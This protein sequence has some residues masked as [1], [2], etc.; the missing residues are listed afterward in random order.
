MAAMVKKNLCLLLTPMSL[1]IQSL[2]PLVKIHRVVINPPFDWPGRLRATFC[3]I[4]LLFASSGVNLAT[5]IGREK[6][7]K[8]KLCNL[9]F[10]PPKNFQNVF[11]N[12]NECIS[13]E[14]P[15]GINTETRRR[16]LD[17]RSTMPM[18][19][20]GHLSAADILQAP[21]LRI[22]GQ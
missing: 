1:A 20:A 11:E 21:T 14:Q 8:K 9:Q 13:I 2:P 5:S 6:S 17:P 18:P 4:A 10:R 16:P 7:Q 19:V 12:F 22:D 3:C 15:V